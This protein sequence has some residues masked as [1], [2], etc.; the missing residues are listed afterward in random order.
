MYLRL[1]LT[2]ITLRFYTVRAAILLNTIHY[3]A[4]GHGPVYKVMPAIMCCAGSLCYQRLLLLKLS[5]SLMQ[6]S[7]LSGVQRRPLAYNVA[8]AIG[9]RG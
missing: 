1:R 8:T 7:A 3:A 4:G 9:Q 5:N 2:R 6:H